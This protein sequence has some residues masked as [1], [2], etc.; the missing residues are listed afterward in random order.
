MMRTV[1]CFVVL[2]LMV[3]LGNPSETFA[4]ATSGRT[5]QE[6]LAVEAKTQTQTKECSEIGNCEG[7]CKSVD[8]CCAPQASKVFTPFLSNFSLESWIC[9]KNIFFFLDNF[10]TGGFSSVWLPPKIG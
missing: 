6:C 9:Y 2:F 3:F 4:C 10:H 7:C 5:A 1:N 8:C